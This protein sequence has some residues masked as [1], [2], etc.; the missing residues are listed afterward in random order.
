MWTKPKAS[1]FD[2]YLAALD[3]GKRAALEKLRR[4]IRA[5]APRAEEHV[6]YGLAAFRLDGKP[7]VAI[8]ASANHCALYPMNGRTVA[9]FKRE[10]KGYDTAKGTIRFNEGQPLPASLVRKIVKA[11]MAE[12]A[13]KPPRTSVART[14]RR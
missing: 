4:T 3:D 8:G 14:R 1:T 9:A 13:A 11:R 2:E 7:L 10:L 5:V 6:A 12:N